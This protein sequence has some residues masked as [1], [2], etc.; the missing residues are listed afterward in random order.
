MRAPF[1]LATWADTRTDLGGGARVVDLLAKVIE[2]DEMP[3]QSDSIQPPVEKL[4]AAEKA[5]LVSWAK[6][7]APGATTACSK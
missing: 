6:A 5:T 2:S 4:T 3:Y 7:C 1:P